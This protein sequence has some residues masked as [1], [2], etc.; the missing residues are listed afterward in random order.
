MAG[1]KP[2]VHKLQLKPITVPQ[3][4]QNGE[5]LIKWDEVGSRMCESLFQ[6]SDLL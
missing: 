2:G 1:A 3:T 6:S 5:N 4:L